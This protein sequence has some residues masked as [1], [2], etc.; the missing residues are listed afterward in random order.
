MGWVA[1]G[2]RNSL[3]PLVFAVIGKGA[4]WLPCWHG[5]DWPCGGA[6]PRASGQP[7]VYKEGWD[8]QNH[9][10]PCMGRAE[11]KQVLAVRVFGV[12]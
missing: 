8:A 5:A 1:L 4:N 11:N 7:H 6:D 12:N 3:N 9:S 2:S 10:G